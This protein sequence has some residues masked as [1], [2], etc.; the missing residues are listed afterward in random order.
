MMIWVRASALAQFK[1]GGI[2]LKKRKNRGLWIL[3]VLCFAIFLFA[4]GKLLQIYLDYKKGADTYQELLEYVEEPADDTKPTPDGE[5][6][7][8]DSSSPYLQVD[9]EGLKKENPDVVAWIEVPALQISYPVVQGTDNSYYLHHMFTG[10][11]SKS[12][13]IF[14]DYHNHADFTDSNT[15]IYGHNMKD[16]TMFGTLDSY[17]D[18]SLYQKDPYFYIYIPD[19]VLK[20]QIVSCYAGRTESIAYTYGFPEPKDFQEFLNKILSCAGYDTGVEVMTTDKIV[21]LSTCV[22]SNRDY[23]YLV[24]G[25]LIEQ[26]EN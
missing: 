2:H 4:A 24:H 19:Y 11:S 13:S 15:I 20:Y 16:K 5:L 26:I 21:T 17:R 1:R 22:N 23:R 3:M 14:V 18:E 6:D 10:E 7:E 12:G 9:F 8:E 25:K